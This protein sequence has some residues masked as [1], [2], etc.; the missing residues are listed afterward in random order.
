MLCPKFSTSLKLDV[1]SIQMLQTIEDSCKNRIKKKICKYFQFLGEMWKFCEI[2]LM[3]KN[4]FWK[5]LS[6]VLMVKLQTIDIHLGHMRRVFFNYHLFL[7]WNSM[8]PRLFTFLMA[9][10]YAMVCICLISG[11][12]SYELKNLS[13]MCP[14]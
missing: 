1:I 8:Q 7:G 6:N 5:D 10:L 12:I 2:F 13:L 11:N 14:R 3:F 9:V 4:F